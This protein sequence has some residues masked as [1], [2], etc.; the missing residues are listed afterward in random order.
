MSSTARVREAGI[1]PGRGWWFIAPG[2]LLLA[3]GIAGLSTTVAFTIAS[4]LWYGVLLLAAG[5]AEIAEAMAKPKK[6]K[7]G[8][9]RTVRAV[10]LLWWW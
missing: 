10:P 2:V 4:T 1:S 5:I 9:S 3:L 7:L 6:S 8:R